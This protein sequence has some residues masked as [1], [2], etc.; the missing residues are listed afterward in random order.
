LDQNLKIQFV[1][2]DMN[3]DPDLGLKASDPQQLRDQVTVVINAAADDSLHKQLPEAVQTNCVSYLTLMTVLAGFSRLRSFLHVSTTYVNSFLPADRIEER[4]YRL[5]EGDHDGYDYD[6]PSG[7]CQRSSRR[8]PQRTPIDFPH[9]M[10]S[11]N[12]LLSG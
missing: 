1:V 9:R 11:P 5:G 2:G 8:V 12:I 4:I 6:D 7:S 10:R 3:R